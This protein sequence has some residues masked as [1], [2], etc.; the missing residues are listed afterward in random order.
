MKF[1][2]LNGKNS[3]G[4]NHSKIYLFYNYPNKNKIIK[5]INLIY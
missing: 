2:I 5:K 1:N 4:T 3:I